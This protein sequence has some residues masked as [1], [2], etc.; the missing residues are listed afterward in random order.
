MILARMIP[1]G[2]CPV[3]GKRAQDHLT[4]LRRANCTTRVLN[5]N[6]CHD[7]LFASSRICGNQ[8]KSVNFFIHKFRVIRDPTLFPFSSSSSLN[9]CKSA[10]SAD[11]SSFLVG[12]SPISVYALPCAFALSPFADHEPRTINHERLPR[13][14]YTQSDLSVL[15]RERMMSTSAILR[16]RFS[17]STGIT[18]RS[19]A[20]C[21][22]STT[23]RPDA[24]ATSIL[25]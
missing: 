14:R 24:S 17:A 10:Q 2:D 6:L 16:C 23:Y 18:M 21:P 25:W 13:Q 4:H 3:I 11:C 19:V 12:R 20:P 5:S 9:Q 8:S 22:A 15:T 1:P 7:S